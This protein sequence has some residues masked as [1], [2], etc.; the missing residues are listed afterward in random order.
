VA[1]EKAKD[2]EERATVEKAEAEKAAQEEQEKAAATV[3]AAADKASEK[4]A[5]A[6]EKLAVTMKEDQKKVEESIRR[7]LRLLWLQQRRMPMPRSL[8]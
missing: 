5:D 2:V 3:K 1:A 8:K 7:R 4:E 6:K